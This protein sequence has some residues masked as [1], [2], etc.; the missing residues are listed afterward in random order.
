VPYLNSQ[1]IDANAVVNNTEGDYYDSVKHT[2]FVIFIV[3]YNI[4]I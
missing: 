1:I 4:S 2:R 3:Y